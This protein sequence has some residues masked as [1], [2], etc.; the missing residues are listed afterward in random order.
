MSEAERIE[1]S[2]AH[3]IPRDVAEALAVQRA[4]LEEG[5]REWKARNPWPALER[6]Y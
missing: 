4:R 1:L 3:G 6:R 2:V 5:A